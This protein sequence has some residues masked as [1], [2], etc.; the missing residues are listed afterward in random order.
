MSGGL[1]Q[2]HTGVIP[3][4]GDFVDK[5]GTLL[6]RH[7]GIIHY[8]IGQRRGLGIS[9]SEPLYV[10]ALSPQSGT[11]V[12]G[13]ASDLYGRE[14]ELSDFNWIGGM[15]TASGIA[16][17]VSMIAIGIRK[18]WI[19]ATAACFISTVLCIWSIFGFI[20]GFFVSMM[21][22]GAKD[23]FYKDYATKLGE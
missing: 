14:A 18:F 11:V 15:C 22:L 17:I 10:C 3:P 12:L 8:T 23:F 2:L 9:S 4:A 1:I 6:G 13:H 20:I 19:V 21:I 7:K 16:G 5:Q